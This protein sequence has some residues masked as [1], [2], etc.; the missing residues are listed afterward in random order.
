MN[1]ILHRL[2]VFREAHRKFHPD[3][4]NMW[5]FVCL[6]YELCEGLSTETATAKDGCTLS[7]TSDQLEGV[8]SKL[9]GDLSHS[10]VA[11]AKAILKKLI[12]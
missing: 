7:V 8:L 10:N 12:D 11:E 4:V 3:G 9:S 6:L 1:D 2:K 5:K